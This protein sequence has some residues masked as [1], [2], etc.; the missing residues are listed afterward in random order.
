[1]QDINKEIDKFLALLEN[2]KNILI[3]GH[4]LPD[5]DSIGSSLA[6]KYLLEYL[7]KN[8]YILSKGIQEKIKNTVD[9]S[10]IK[11]E[12]EELKNIKLDMVIALDL[13]KESRIHEEYLEYVKKAKKVVCIDHHMGHEKFG[14][15]NIVEIETATAQ[16]IYKIIRR[17]LGEKYEEFKKD[18]KTREI[19]L[20][21]M[22]NI[23]LGILTDSGGFRHQNTNILS[24]EIAKEA[25]EENIDIF[26]IYRI[27]VIEKSLNEFEMDKITRKRMQLYYGGKIAYSYLCC[28]DEPYINR[29]MGE[30]EALVNIGKEI[31]GVLVTIFTREV[32]NGFRI[33]VRTNAPYSALNIAKAFNGGGH[34]GAAGADIVI[35]NLESLGK[36]E[37][38]KL[39][40]YIKEKLILKASFEIDR[41]DEE[42]KKGKK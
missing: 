2:T 29:K 3:L 39:F 14:D 11:E 10:E 28:E 16:I 26:N 13:P 25:K 38:E 15:V 4:V 42:M 18:E 20:K 37:K 24:F 12:N 32:E 6:L 8:V 19:Y 30:G 33:S 36:E 35:S 34:E 9:V 17:V 21:M 22:E 31:E 40:N 27:N 23:M 1:M 5:G 7:G 41:K